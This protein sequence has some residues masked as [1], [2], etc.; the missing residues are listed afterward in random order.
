MNYDLE[1]FVD[2]QRE[3]YAR[4]LGEITKGRKQTHWIWYVFPQLAGLGRSALARF[5]AIH[6]L[7]EA[8]AY[9]AHPILGPRLLECVTALQNLPIPDPVA[10][11][12]SVDAKKVRSCLTLF[13]EAAPKQPLFNATLDRWFGGHKDEAT[14]AILGG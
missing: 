9:L 8:R 1:R 13:A 7:E 11:F 6:S 14:L 3:S 12:G 10:V 5:F 2:A 4:A